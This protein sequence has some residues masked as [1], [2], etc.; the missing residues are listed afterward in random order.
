MRPP[1]SS[2]SPIHCEW[3]SHA[4]VIG[5]Q[6]SLLAGNLQRS[7]RRSARSVRTQSRKVAFTSSPSLAKLRLLNVFRKVNMEGVAGE[8][9]FRLFFLQARG[10]LPLTAL[11]L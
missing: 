8:V 4:F 7:R 1:T 3:I 6:N 9:S 5:V 10:V 2:G 11:L